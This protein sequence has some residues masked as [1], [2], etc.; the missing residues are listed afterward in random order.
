[1][2]NLN[3]LEGLRSQ[4]FPNE[5]VTAGRYEIMQISIEG[6]RSFQLKRD[7]ALMYAQEKYVDTS[8]TVE[9]L[10]FTVQQYFCMRDPTLREISSPLSSSNNLYLQVNKTRYRQ[11]L[12]KRLMFSNIRRNLRL[13]LSNRSE[14]VL[15]VVTHRTFVRLPFERPS[16]ETDTTSN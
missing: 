13:T 5:E 16:T 12:P 1:M 10:R 3:E 14:H 9:A 15:P 2:Q 11:R 7:F 4:G 8:P 6:V